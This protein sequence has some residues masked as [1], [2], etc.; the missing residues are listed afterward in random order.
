MAWLSVAQVVAMSAYARLNC[1]TMSTCG[2][3]Y[4]AVGWLA[5]G[6][7]AAGQGDKQGARQ[8]STHG[9]KRKQEV[10]QPW[11]GTARHRRQ[12]HHDAAKGGRSSAKAANSTLWDLGHEA[13]AHG[14]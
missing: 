1:G 2:G 12:M 6:G 10:Q 14:R 4:G 9:R 11:P 13:A 7:G 8:A 5:G 3:A